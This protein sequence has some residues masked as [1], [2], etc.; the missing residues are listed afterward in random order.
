MTDAQPKSEP[1][2]D[3]PLPP[4][5]PSTRSLIA[6]FVL[7][8][9]LCGVN[10]YLT[11][12]FGVIEEG[13]T[14]AALFFF[15]FFFLSRTKI[16]PAEMV[17]VATMGSAGG[18]L[19]FISNFF[20][21][22]AMTGE[23][24]SFFQMAGFAVVTSL[25]GMAFTIPLRQ[26]LILRE[27]LPWP[28]SKATASVIR[29]LV[30]STDRTQP[31]I[32]AVTCVLGIAFVVLNDDGGF[33]LIPAETA[34]PL[35]GLAALGIAWSPFAIGGAYLM[36]L[37]T[38]V[39][40]LFGAI[41]L[42]IM[43]PY[44]PQPEAP[45]R[46]VW[47]G[48]GF[49]LASG[50]TTM[51]L[52]WKVIRDSIVSLIQRNEG[53][54]VD[55]DP[56]M[57]GRSFLIFTTLAVVITAIFSSA[58]MGLSII[59]TVLLVVVGGLV[60]NVIATRAAAQTAFNP[61]R[62]MGVLLQGITAMAGA[63]S[64]GANLAGAGF[65]AGSGAQAGNLTGDLV[66]G[67]WLRVPSRWQWWAQ[68]TT[69]VPCSLVSAWVFQSL[70]SSRP[71]TLEGEGLPAP[72]AKM[73]AATA[74]IFEGTSEMPPFAWQ[75]L[76]IGGAAGAVYVLLEQKE[77]IKRWLPCS[78]GLGI[79]LVLPVSFDLAFFVGGILLFV[80]GERVLKIEPVSLTTIAVGCIVAEG[81]GGV[82]KPLLSIA[83]VL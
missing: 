49:L 54:K 30:S 2:F 11:L 50:L 9:V 12:S 10:S 71:M 23:P 63:S 53:E 8:L 34:I 55:D 82:L 7:A 40:F 14:I 35:F 3:A 24:Y 19:G 83:G 28:G 70:Q 22:R 62:V 64:A 39:G 68:L 47:P 41:V 72:V 66:Y 79:G 81:L 43:A 48:I 29:A 36:G 32:L 42:L 16:I 21:A 31:L 6:G 15:A 51:A 17:I 5:R 44:L 58:F 78:I 27:D 80:L 26:M 59:V 67:R 25:V 46:Y 1:E 73:W 75:A 13:P 56:I 38:C 65:V 52:N 57:S 77:E 45:H 33:G 76:A 4:P 37:R 69:V 61:A 74:L 18:S 20:A 60:Q